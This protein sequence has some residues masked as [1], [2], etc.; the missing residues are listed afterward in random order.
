MFRYFDDVSPKIADLNGVGLVENPAA[1][2]ED[3]EI[4]NPSTPQVPIL[5]PIFELSLLRLRFC[6]FI[7][8]WRLLFAVLLQVKE[9]QIY[10]CD[11][12]GAQK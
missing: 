8:L 5:T 1:Q 10:N 11:L 2:R 9:V 12:E 6:F 7:I 4:L 3:Q